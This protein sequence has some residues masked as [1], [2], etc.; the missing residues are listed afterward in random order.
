M[1]LFLARALAGGEVMAKPKA[2]P[3][4]PAVKTIHP[5]GRTVMVLAVTASTDTKAIGNFLRATRR[6]AGKTQAFVGGKLDYAVTQVAHIES[7]RQEPRLTRMGNYVRSLG[8]RLFV[9]VTEP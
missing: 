6:E 4:A 2:A 7:G 3:K 9:I 1:A 5:H 8:R